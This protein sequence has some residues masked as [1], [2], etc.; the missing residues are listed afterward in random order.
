MSFVTTVRDYVETL[1]TISDAF[2][3]ELTLSSFISQTVFYILKTVQSSLLYIVSFQWIRDF[4]LL[5]IVLPQLTSA[6]FKESF[7]LE[8][9]SKVFFQFLELPDLHQNKFLLGFLNS[10]FLSLPLSIVHIISIR[11]LLIQGIPAG[12]YSIGGYLVGQLFLLTCSI[13]GFRQVLIPWLTL[14]PLNYVIGV[15]LIFRLLYSLTQENLIELKGWS[16][17]TYS[18]FFITSFALAWCEQT[19]VFQYLGN[20]TLSTN[21]TIL[22][23]FSSTTSF[24]SFFIHILYLLGLTIGS[25][26]FTGLFGFLAL[27]LRNWIIYS[28]PLSTSKF[29]KWFNK[30][31]FILALAL[32]LTSV[33]F[34]SFEYLALAPLGFVSQDSV[35]KSTIF[36]QSLLKDYSK[37]LTGMATPE[38]LFHYIDLEV[39]PF[40]RGEYLTA[41]DVQQP[42][43]FEDLNYRGEV[44]WVRRIEKVS[45]I[46]DSKS[47]F[48]TLSKLFKKQPKTGVE[49]Q[50]PSQRQ[51][52][53]EKNTLLLSG[54]FE[55]DA[56]NGPGQHDTSSEIVKRYIQ[57]YDGNTDSLES[58]QVPY[59]QLYSFSFPKDFL[60]KSAKIESKVEQKI[61]DKYYSNPIY[62]NLLTLDIDLFLKRQPETFKL[63]PNQETDLY[64]KRRMLESYANSLKAYSQLPSNEAFDSFFDGAKSFSNK[65][66]NQQFKGTL[67]SVR[68]LFTLSRSAPQTIRTPVGDQ[69]G[70]NFAS[71]KQDK[72]SYKPT[73]ETI[74]AFDQPLYQWKNEKPFSPYHEELGSKGLMDQ[75]LQP[76]GEFGAPGLIGVLKKGVDERAFFV[77]Q[78]LYAGWDERLRKFVITNKALPR[79]LAGYRVNL[80]NQQRKQEGIGQKIKFT[81]WPLSKTQLILKEPFSSSPASQGTL[82]SKEQGEV[83]GSSSTN[84]VPYV[85]LYQFLDA[86]AKEVLGDQDFVTLPANLQRWEFQQGQTEK[87][88]GEKIKQP[89]LIPVRGGFVWPGNAPLKIPFLK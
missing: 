32:S 83:K 6:L 61:K 14:E 68:R 24:S 5:P 22:E 10:L 60:R 52:T 34:Y 42:L 86:K 67:R 37:G 9:P 30:S 70:S 84:V 8:T 7:F 50:Q 71:Q 31:S 54:S 63:T 3:E 17:S 41:P 20:L 13:F 48:F 43:S 66:Y 27:R 49:A 51:K 80:P 40:D 35:F 15:L 74:L 16:R 76:T 57:F 77:N 2:G 85:T 1:N 88:K 56:T 4:S 75:N 53:L 46:T 39:A 45:G 12:V 47:G 38:R 19:S 36:D 29:L 28:T 73:S 89:S 81:V 23:S 79:T 26:L 21:V 25:V 55:S 65:V 72:I 62:K 59:Q 58:F 33:P 82:V 64:T 11:R 87:R 44:D 18:E 69:N 78:P